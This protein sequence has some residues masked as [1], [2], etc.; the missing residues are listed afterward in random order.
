MLMFSQVKLIKHIAKD[1]LQGKN[2]T[3]KT[4]RFIRK[5]FRHILVRLETNGNQHASKWI[6]VSLMNF[7]ISDD[8]LIMTNGFSIKEK[9]HCKP[10]Y[11]FHDESHWKSLTKNHLMN[12]IFVSVND[13]FRASRKLSIA[14]FCSSVIALKKEF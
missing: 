6:S 8:V 14:T 5:S 11:D 4:F 7:R 2:G 10:Y 12:F 9:Y 1:C 3:H 13:C